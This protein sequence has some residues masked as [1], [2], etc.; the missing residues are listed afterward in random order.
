MR[1]TKTD[2]D[3]TV[4]VIAGAYVV[5]FGMNLPKNKTAKFL[6]FAIQRKDQENGEVVWMRGMKTFKETDPND[7]IGSDFSS[8]EHP[9][10]SFQWADYTVKPDHKYSYKI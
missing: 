3:L 2:G 7:S 5:Y 1:I 8:R 10:Q 9:F 4:R 6:G